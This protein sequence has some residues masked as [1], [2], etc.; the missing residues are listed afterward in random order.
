MTMMMMMMISPY[1]HGRFPQI[2]EASD[3]VA[4]S[5]MKAQD[6]LRRRK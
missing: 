3:S 5:K 1:W 2:F 6:F 4:D